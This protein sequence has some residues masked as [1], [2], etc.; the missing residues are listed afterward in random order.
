MYCTRR[1]QRWQSLRAQRAS[2][3]PFMLSG[4]NKTSERIRAMASTGPRYPAHM[5]FPT[6]RFPISPLD[7]L[8]ASADNA[9]RVLSGAQTASRPSPGA[10]A[11]DEAQALTDDERRLSGALM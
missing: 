3:A 10:A 9:L 5:I 1:Q 8:I 11:V 4:N 2:K 7:V 6:P